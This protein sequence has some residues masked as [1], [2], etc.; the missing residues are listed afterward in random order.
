MRRTLAAGLAAVATAVGSAGCGS[1]ETAN[2]TVP[3]DAVAIVD[4]TPISMQEYETWRRGLIAFGGV[5]ADPPQGPGYEDCIE[6]MRGT[7]SGKGASDGELRERCAGFDRD[8][9]DRAMSLL[10]T[11]RWVVEE[12]A[13]QDIELTEEEVAAEHARI[14]RETFPDDA[15]YRRFLRSGVTEEQLHERSR[16]Q[17]LT[18][19]LQEA[20]GA[21]DPVTDED[22]EAFYREH[23]DRFEVPERRDVRVVVTKSG[24]DARA[25]LRA[26][27]AG[28][29]WDEVAKQYSRSKAT[30]ETG[31]LYEGIVRAQ[32]GPKAGEAVFGAPR[33]ELV[34]PVRVERTTGWIV[35]EVEDI[36]PA[37]TV[38]LADVEAQIAKELRLAREVSQRE[39]WQRALRDEWRPLTGCRDPYVTGDC[40]NGPDE[41]ARTSTTP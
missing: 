16:V 27:E 21:P 34:G 37:T 36:E 6:R 15:S 33:G 18:K 26:L 10:I 32:Q 30:R 24:Q 14:K 20:H 25:A 7:R 39:Q 8:L 1:D 23:G 19:R 5:V 4:G 12:A 17:L 3:A 41:P 28:A 35:F 9:R 38:P 29:S 11:G 13:E 40:S 31:G 2:L 22:V